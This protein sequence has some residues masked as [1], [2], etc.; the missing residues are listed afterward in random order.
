MLTNIRLTTTFK[1]RHVDDW[2][3][4]MPCPWPCQPVS[5][6]I[7]MMML[8]SEEVACTAATETS[9][10]KAAAHFIVVCPTEK[11]R[12]AH[13][14]VPRLESAE[15][16]FWR[17]GTTNR[18]QQSVRAVAFVLINGSARK[19]RPPRRW[20]PRPGAAGAYCKVGISGFSSHVGVGY[21][22]SLADPVTMQ[23]LCSSGPIHCN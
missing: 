3:Q 4:P 7:A 13:F 10:A 1:R 2:C 11:P 15:F 22:Q 20:S 8:G 5:P 19:R 9:I 12:G 16:P 23:V 21:I 14:I 17:S 6:A 18:Y